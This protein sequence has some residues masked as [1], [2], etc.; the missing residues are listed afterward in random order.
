MHR[1]EMTREP[2]AIARLENNQVDEWHRRDM[3]SL[4]KSWRTMRSRL[5]ASQRFLGHLP[6]IWQAN[7]EAIMDPFLK[8]ANE[9]AVPVHPAEALLRQLKSVVDH[10]INLPAAAANG[11]TDNIGTDEGEF[12]CAQ[13]LEAVETYLKG[14]S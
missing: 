9:V 2:D 3:L 8:A 5:Q 12:R 14:K 1:P 11:V 4:I 13:L 7:Q 6:V 10:T